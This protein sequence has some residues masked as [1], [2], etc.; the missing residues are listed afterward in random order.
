MARLKNPVECGD[1][2]RLRLEGAIV[3]AAGGHV[4]VADDVGE[5]DVAV[6][7]DR[8]EVFDRRGDGSGSERVAV[9]V[10]LPGEA[11]GP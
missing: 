5:R 4:R 7:E 8:Q 3:L 10:A 2:C 1:E 9:G 6:L 11:D